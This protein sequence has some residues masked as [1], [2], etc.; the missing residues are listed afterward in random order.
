MKLKVQTS[1][2]LSLMIS[3]QMI[4]APVA[5]AKAEGTAGTTDK[6]KTTKNSDDLSFWDKAGNTASDILQ[7]GAGAF[8]SYQGAQQNNMMTPE[9]AALQANMQPSPDKYFNSTFM[10][11]IPGLAE[12][13]AVMGKNS[14]LLNCTT[15]PAELNDVKSPVCDISQAPADFSLDSILNAYK[16]TYSDIEKMYKNYSA[17]SNV[18]GTGFGYSCMKDAKEI[19]KGF[20]DYRA[21]E[22][23]NTIANIEALN[24]KFKNAAKADMDNIEESTALLSG[25]NSSITNKVKTAK[26][27]LFDFASQFNDAA[28]KSMFAGENFKTAGTNKGLLSIEEMVVAATDAK[29]KSQNGSAKTFSGA[30]FT[31]AYQSVVDDLNNLATKIS[32]QSTTNFSSLAGFQTDLSRMTSSSTYG[33]EKAL[34]SSNVFTEAQQSFNES[35]QKLQT[36]LAEVTAELQSA[37]G[38]TETVNKLMTNLNSGTFD[39]EVAKIQTGIENQCLQD[40]VNTDT[41]I[42]KMVDPQMSS[43]GNKNVPSFIKEKIK[44][45][46]ENK[47]SS[48]DKKLQELIALEKQGANKYYVK[49][50]STYEVQEEVNGVIQKTVV[51]PSTR[52]TPTA[53]IADVIKSC[54]AQFKSNTLE[55]KYSG[56]SA[57]A[58]LKELRSSY[59]AL[60]TATA[61]DIKKKIQDKFIN[62]DSQIAANQDN[63]AS[64]SAESF[65]M[66]SANFCANSALSC[67]K[68][69]QSCKAKSQKIVADIKTKRQSSITNYKANVE[70]NRKDLVAIFDTALSAFKMQ[71]TQLGSIFNIPWESPTGIERDLKEGTQFNDALKQADPALLIEDPDKYVALLKTNLTKLKTNIQSQSKEIMGILDSHVE[72][73]KSSYTKNAGLAKAEYDKCDQTEKQINKN[74]GEAQKAEKEANDKGMGVCLPFKT[75]TKSAI[76]ICGGASQ[77]SEDSLKAAYAISQ[78]SKAAELVSTI[79]GMCEEN[80]EASSE[81]ETLDKSNSGSPVE[82]GKKLT[83]KQIFEEPMKD[84]ALTAEEKKKLCKK[85][86]GLCDGNNEFVNANESFAD[87]IKLAEVSF[88]DN[89][90]TV[91]EYNDKVKGKSSGNKYSE[92]FKAAVTELGVQA[93][94]ACTSQSGQQANL[95]NLFQ[96]LGEHMG[97]NTGSK[98]KGQ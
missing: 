42:A 95:K 71:G 82:I 85:N 13:M 72:K 12:Y 58:K 37:G 11:K 56:A 73:A 36:Q 10:N 29:P 80:A 52:K 66:S 8:N 74:I 41:V 75:G 16:T 51:T 83:C 5:F 14:A 62:C 59:K 93:N 31:K 25:G 88:C 49:L 65:D 23:D 35:N 32:S 6:D 60:A 19:L 18:G 76:A 64:C 40:S 96:G 91:K 92:S 17:E 89:A 27:A 7:L 63:T 2:F 44:Q 53:F 46:M 3:Y 97:S 67:S 20:F 98:V 47:L 39:Q 55:T 77:V 48:T 30:T 45:I 69:M 22:M 33:L 79:K 87:A 70:K 78:Y 15:L 86:T 9:L 94:T 50:D 38:N 24:T 84:I 1:R 34:S 68:N 61:A 21:K 28:C 43:Y 57:I 90:K 26:P 4:V 54:K 81:V